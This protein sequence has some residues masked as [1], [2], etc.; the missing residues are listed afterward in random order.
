MTCSFDNMVAIYD[1]TTGEWSRWFPAPGPDDSGRDVHHFNTVRKIGREIC[2]IAHRFGPSEILFYDSTTLQ[3]NSTVSIGAQSHDIFLFDDALATCSSGDGCLVN[4]SGKR[5]RTGNFPR[6]IATTS[7]GA[8]LGLS[9]LSG[10]AQRASQNGILRWYTPDWR[11]Q[12]DYIL[13]RVGMVL[14]IVELAEQEHDW[15]ALEYWPDAEITSGEYNRV[16]P[17]NQY[18]P[19]SFAACAAG[20]ALEW[21]ATEETH[22]WTAAERATLSILVNPGETRLCVEVES[23]F[24]GPYHAE[25]WL[26]EALLGVARF[27]MPGTQQHKFRIPAGVVGPALLSFRVP[28]LWRPA[29]LIAGSNDERLLGLAVRGAT[30]DL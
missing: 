30:V 17:G 28:H 10:R 6:G 15:Q 12:A 26:D 9:V 2:L 4:I 14:D 24:P 20:N 22:C 1:L 27:S 3:L 11:F 23:T 29:E 25:I 19:N 21:H 13:P 8:L 18:T 5:L 7:E 16:A